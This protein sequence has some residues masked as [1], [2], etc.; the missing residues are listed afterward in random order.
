MNIRGYRL[1][2][3]QFRSRGVMEHRWSPRTDCEIP[4]LI[5]YRDTFRIR[6]TLTNVSKA[7]LGLDTGPV[8]LPPGAVVALAI[9]PCSAGV[10]SDPVVAMVIHSFRGRAGLW[11][12][13]D[14]E[15]YGT[16][17]AFI[18]RAVRSSL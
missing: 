16:L 13:D 12:G 2:K 10:Q 9:D 14:P 11:L 18:Q 5:H 7:G 17:M 4:V 8:H 6:C 15:Q 1:T 3:G